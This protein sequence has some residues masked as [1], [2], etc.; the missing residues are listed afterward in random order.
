MAKFQIKLL[1]S[2]HYLFGNKGAVWTNTIHI[3]SKG[4]TTLCGTAMLSTNWSAYLDDPKPG[5][6]ECLRI[7]N[8]N[9]QKQIKYN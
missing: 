4:G 1:D 2:E 3:A 5:C 6:P 8:E 9:I 7:Y